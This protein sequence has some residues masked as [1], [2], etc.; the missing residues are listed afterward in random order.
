MS[1]IFILCGIDNGVETQ[2]RAEVE[3]PEGVLEKAF[4]YHS[5]SL[6]QTARAV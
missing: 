1:L 4:F 3:I 2:N 5:V 6:A